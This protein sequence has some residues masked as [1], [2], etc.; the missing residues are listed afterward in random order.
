MPPLNA[1][2]ALIGLLL[3]CS[4]SAFVFPLP[5]TVA[6]VSLLL[7]QLFLTRKDTSSTVTPKEEDDE[8]VAALCGLFLAFPCPAP[9]P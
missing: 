2:A 5:M 9:P 4:A 6:A 7:P 1:A 8:E 3:P